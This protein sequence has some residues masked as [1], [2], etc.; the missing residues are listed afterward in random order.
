MYGV[1]EDLNRYNE[2]PL[3]KQRKE[4]E[5][6]TDRVASL[7]LELT[8][9]KERYEILCGTIRKNANEDRNEEE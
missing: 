8:I 7:E 1:R 5:F 9:S 3:T 6:L 2:Y 4:I